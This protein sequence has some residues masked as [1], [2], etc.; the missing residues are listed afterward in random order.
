MAQTD[1]HEVIAAKSRPS[2]NYD[3]DGWNAFYAE[4]PGFRRT[5][6]AASSE[7]G[8][9][10][11]GDGGEGAEPG[12]GEGAPSGASSP[13]YSFVPEKFL[14]DGAPDGEAF[15]NAYDEL[16]AY[17]A[18]AEE[19]KAGLPEDAEG[20][21]FDVPEGFE[22]PEGVP[23]EMK[24]TFKFNPDDPDIPAVKAW[25]HENG[26]SQQGLNALASLMAQREARAVVEAAEFEATERKALGNDAD[27]RLKT[28]ERNLR[29]RLPG[30]LAEAIVSSAVSANAVRAIEKLLSGP[31][32]QTTTPAPGPDLSKMTP[33][34]KLEHA[35]RL[36]HEA[37]RGSRRA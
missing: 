14:K 8:E 32:K 23:D 26:V 10:T 36:A 29:S 37:G 28:L 6:S 7:G 35:N 25:A 17:R 31:G 12:Q 22:W 5:L 15:R 20:Y 21:A 13:D 9:G 27:S 24:A 30:D 1:R 4:H 18:Q 16:A 33:F 2:D 34:Q 11:P 3:V 19:A